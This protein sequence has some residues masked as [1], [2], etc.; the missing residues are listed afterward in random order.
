MSLF[1]TMANSPECEETEDGVQVAL[2]DQSA[3]LALDYV[4]RMSQIPVEDDI[5]AVLDYY[6]VYDYTSYE[7]VFAKE[8]YFRDN[9]YTFTNH[10][11]NKDPYYDLVKVDRR[12][13]EMM[14]ICVNVE[15]GDSDFMFNPKQRSFLR[16]MDWN[17]VVERLGKINE[18]FTHPGQGT[19]IVVA[20]GYV[21]CSLFGGKV[22]DVDIFFVGC[23][24]DTALSIVYDHNERLHKG[25]A[26]YVARTK[27]CISFG[28]EGKHDYNREF[29]NNINSM[30]Y[31]Y[32]LRLYQSPSEV[33]HSFDVDCCC[34]LYDGDSI[35][36]TKRC[37]LA[38]FNGYNT[39]NFD[40][41]SPSYEYR[42]SKYAS[43]GIPLKVEGLDREN[44]IHHTLDQHYNLTFNY[45]DFY[46]N[47][48]DTW[49]HVR[50]YIN[51]NDNDFYLPYT[52]SLQN[53]ES[54]LPLILDE[55]LRT[56]LAKIIESLL[57]FGINK[58][59]YSIDFGQKYAIQPKGLNLLLF[60]EKRFNCIQDDERRKNNLEKL[61]KDHSD[62]SC[63]NLVYVS[64]TRVSN[65]LDYLRKCN[66]NP[67]SLYND[68]WKT[69]PFR[70]PQY[71][72]RFKLIY[73]NNYPLNKNI[74]CIKTYHLKEIEKIMDID[75]YLVTVF[76]NFGDFSIGKRPNFKT[77]NPGEQTTSTFHKIVLED[78]EQWYNGK[79]YWV[80]GK[81]IIMGIIFIDTNM[82]RNKISFHP[83]ISFHA[84]KN[85][86]RKCFCWDHNPEFWNEDT[87]EKITD[88]PAVLIV[89][90]IKIK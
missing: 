41:L 40:L 23:D 77:I 19:P 72:E 35:Y 59:N 42:L 66:D 87:G 20:G 61:G 84:L 74:M 88:M 13:F 69:V 90:T 86:V 18:L 33:I 81:N 34:M 38:L 63:S 15:A 44:I 50:K 55:A 2:N 25:R 17:F 60:L 16:K 52:I 76:S 43:R 8:K 67:S 32:I 30:E 57:H 46:N 85:E 7:T 3:S 22:N 65:I 80:N 29:R 14:R 48:R 82:N 58:L 62:Y 31:Q 39:V 26:N 64:R 45:G 24:S 10:Q 53:I 9:L 75:D 27:N 1:R 71:H 11:M 12:V 36:L 83:S 68:I 78:T 4:T 49:N 56:Q 89:K 51:N 54:V 5:A 73:V 37:V 79:F 21:F 28:K 6:G 47:A 70:S